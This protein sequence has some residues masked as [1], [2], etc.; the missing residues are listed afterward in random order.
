VSSEPG[1]SAEIQPENALI[2]TTLSLNQY[3]QPETEETPHP[4]IQSVPENPG[5]D[6]T[7]DLDEEILKIIEEELPENQKE[8]EIHS[9]LVN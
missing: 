7:L 1:D 3:S 4:P 2:T 5:K 9:S 8:L 6:D